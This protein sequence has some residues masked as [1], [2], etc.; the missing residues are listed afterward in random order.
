MNPAYILR[1]LSQKEGRW[2]C[3]G[4]AHFPR[5][6]S[7]LHVADAFYGIGCAA[8]VRLGSKLVYYVGISAKDAM[9]YGAP[10]TVGRLEL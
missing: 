6:E 5:K 3:E 10:A 8:V 7:A 1:T 4:E 2:H 9:L